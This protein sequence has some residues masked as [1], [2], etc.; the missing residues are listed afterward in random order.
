MRYFPS[1]TSP[2]AT[3]DKRHSYN[4]VKPQVHLQE[5]DGKINNLIINTTQG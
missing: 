1:T 4:L 5:F 2:S 3:P